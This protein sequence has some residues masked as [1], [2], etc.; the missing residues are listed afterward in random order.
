MLVESNQSMSYLRFCFVHIVALPLLTIGSVKQYFAYHILKCSHY[1][2]NLYV[3][4]AVRQ[5]VKVVL[6]WLR[7]SR[8]GKNE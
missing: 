2:M 8:E 4:V 1:L 7:L 3:D 6:P 5:V